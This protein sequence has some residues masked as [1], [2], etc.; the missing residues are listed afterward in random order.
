MVEIVFFFIG[1]MPKAIFVYDDV[2]NLKLRDVFIREWNLK[3]KFVLYNSA[4]AS[5]YQD[6]LFYK[7]CFYK[8]S[9]NILKNK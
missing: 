2:V 9:D 6:F 3:C 5:V 8:L 4:L 1:N 7:V